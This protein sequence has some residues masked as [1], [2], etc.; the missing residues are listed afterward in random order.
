LVL[1]IISSGLIVLSFL[2]SKILFKTRIILPKY[3]IKFNIKSNWNYNFLY[4]KDF[5]NIF[6]Y[7]NWYR[8]INVLNFISSFLVNYIVKELFT[9]ILIS[10]HL[11]IYRSYSYNN[12]NNFTIYRLEYIVMIL[13]S[14]LSFFSFFFLRTRNGI[15]SLVCAR[16]FLHFFPFSSFGST[17]VWTHI[18]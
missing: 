18:C 4:K 8:H 5:K 17:G 9:S 13:L 10:F 15:Y 6:N 3:F 7:L 1:V 12:Y 11:N 16:R 14:C 2:L